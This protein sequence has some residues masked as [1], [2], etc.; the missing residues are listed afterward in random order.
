M[1]RKVETALCLKS[2]WAKNC[3]SALWRLSLLGNVECCSA[4]SIAPNS[5][6]NYEFVFDLSHLGLWFRKK[7]FWC[8][9]CTK[10]E[11]RKEPLSF[12]GVF[13]LVRKK[14]QRVAYQRKYSWNFIFWVMAV[15]R[16]KWEQFFLSWFSGWFQESFSSKYRTKAREHVKWELQCWVRSNSDLKF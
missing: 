3:L 13:Y 11:D 15:W 12:F 14:I 10:V 16:L 7:L 2:K 8:H 9:S 5:T 6:C 1:L 4:K